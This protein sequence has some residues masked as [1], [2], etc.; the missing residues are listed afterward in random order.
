M[1]GYAAQHFSG[2]PNPGIPQTSPTTSINQL[3]LTSLHPY[4]GFQSEEVIKATYQVTSLHAGM[5]PTND[6]LK[7]YFMTDN[8]VFNIPH[9]NKPIITDTVMSD[10]PVIDD[11]S[12]IPNSFVD[13]IL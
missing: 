7:K 10:A 8:P 11:D 9:Y 4:F 6:Y 12:T 2:Y 1:H 5:D 3:G 13:K